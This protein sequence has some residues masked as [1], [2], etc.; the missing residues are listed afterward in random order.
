MDFGLDRKKMAVAVWILGDQLLTDNPALAFAEKLIGR[1]QV[2]ILMIESEARARRFAYQA[3]KLVLLFSAMRHFAEELRSEGYQVDYRISSSTSKAINQHIEAYKPEYLVTMAASEY[4]GNQYQQD[5]EEMLDIP[6]DIV[7][8]TQFLTGIY[9]P[10]LEPQPGKRYLQEMFY[11]NMRKHFNLLMGADGEP[12]GG[13]WN[14][15]KENRRKLPKG[16]KPT[17]PATFEPDEITRG[18]MSEVDQKF[19]GVGEVWGFDLAVTHAEAQ[20][21]AA[22]FFEHRLAGFGAYEDAMSSEFQTINHSKL[23]PYLNIGLLEPLALAREAQVRY[24]NDKAPI[25]S[26][27][28]FVRQV[29]GWREFMYWQYWRLMPEMENANYWKA[30]RHLPDFF[31]NGKTQLNCLNHVITRGLESGYAHHIER[32]MVAANFCLLAGIDPKEVNAWFLSLFIDAYEWVMLPNVFGM[33]LY[34]DGGKISTKP[35]IASA[36]YLHK[37]SDYC[38]KCSFNRKE[39]IGENACPFNFLYW[40]FILEN[41][42]KLRSNPRMGRSLLALR[43]LTEEE[44]HQIMIQ[45]NQFFDRVT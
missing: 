26:V 33:G 28:G 19:N 8:N 44:R 7:P 38:V 2:I 39:R 35:Y 36:N 37:M 40:N 23:S 29:V 14:F 34:A 9:N 42:E 20:D 11:R 27:E 3:K 45:A 30:T 6:V 41:E 25:N 1:D 4:Y 13:K 21:A 15:D 32:L 12:Y 31:W 17:P 18:V 43:H 16:L 10:I 5:L 24:E 22:D